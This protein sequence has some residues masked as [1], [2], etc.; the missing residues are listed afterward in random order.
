MRVIYY[1]KEY[2]RHSSQQNIYSRKEFDNKVHE[3][4]WKEA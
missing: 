1:V 2:L 3:G 4:K